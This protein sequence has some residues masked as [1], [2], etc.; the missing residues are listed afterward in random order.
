MTIRYTTLASPTLRAAYDEAMGKMRRQFTL[1]PAGKPIIPDEVTLWGSITGSGLDGLPG[2][3][4]RCVIIS[5]VYLLVRC[6]LGCLMVLTRHQVSK[7]PSF[8]C[9]GA[10]TWSCAA[11][12]VSVAVRKYP[13]AARLWSPVL[14][15]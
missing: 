3:D 6:L 4:H 12:L 2:W 1:T 13:Q 7:M 14:A 11:R 10:R 5:V 15:S 8:W 9:S